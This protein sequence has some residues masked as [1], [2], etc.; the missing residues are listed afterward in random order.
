MELYHFF[1]EHYLLAPIEEIW[2]TLED[3][4]AWPE[5]SAGFKNIVI[6]GDEPKLE[7]G[8][9]I[10]CEVK[11][12]LPYTLRF[13]LEVRVIQPPTIMEYV[14]TGDL[15]GTG[16]WVLESQEDGTLVKYYWDVG[17]TSRLFNLLGKISFI[18][19]MLESNHDRVM[20][21]AYRSLKM[22]LEKH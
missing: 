1:S 3:A 22:R 12:S 7:L 16:K 19:R 8:S 17:T 6:Q 10:H 2:E 14:A 21:E 15:Q 4:E 20:D 5:W 18:K 11:G 9:R 13:E